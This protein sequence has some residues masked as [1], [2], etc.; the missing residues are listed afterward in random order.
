[1]VFS[2]LCSYLQKFPVPVKPLLRGAPQIQP[3]ASP[4]AIAIMQLTRMGLDLRRVV[5]LQTRYR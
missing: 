2:L 3:L 5:V 4:L 1:H